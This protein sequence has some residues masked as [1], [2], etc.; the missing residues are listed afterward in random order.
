MAKRT[1]LQ[2]YISALEAFESALLDAQEESVIDMEQTH[3]AETDPNLSPG[4][5]LLHIPSAPGMAAHRAG[6][7]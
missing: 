1:P 2:K 4:E 6:I 7:V 3:R 5:R